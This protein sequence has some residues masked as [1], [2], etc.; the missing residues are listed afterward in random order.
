MIT[1]VRIDGFKS[2]LDFRLDVPPVMVVL[3]LNAA[4]KSNFFDALRLVSGTLRDGFEATVAADRRF[5]ARDLFH[6]GGPEG[7]PVREDFTIT[8]GALVRSPDGPLPLRVRLVARY[9]PGPGRRPGRAVLDPARSAV[10]VSSLKNRDWMDRLGLGT[11]MREAI[12]A[13][14]RAFL[15]RTRTPHLRIL[16]H[17]FAAHPPGP[18]TPPPAGEG[19]PAELVSL[20]LRECAGWQPLL[21]SPEAMRGLVPVGPDAPLDH[22]GRNLPL[23]LDRI[24][25]EAPTA[26]RRLVADLAGVVEGVRDVRTRYLES[27]Q[28]FDYEVE[29]EHTGW[30]APPLL[31]DGTVRTLALLAAC[32]DP[33]RR[34]TLCVEEIENGMHP[35]RVADLVRRLRRGCGADPAGS[36]APF[37]QLLAST[38]SPALLAALRTDLTGSLVFMEQVDR[39]DPQR[40]AVSRVSVAR[41]LRERDLSEEPGETM[42]PQQVDRLLRRLA[43]GA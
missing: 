1:Q 38:H 10:W 33:L 42:S 41:P 40:Q 9:E 30:T 6:R 11:E 22:D 20:V 24:E 14:R 3:G 13:A 12:A 7:R 27:R 23:V 34:G 5:A 39:V 2:F 26:W 31:S 16:D 17:G 36:G 29:F 25:S 35:T 32:A 37:R 43:Q 18:G 21:L 28:E 4:G 8:V 19:G 15:L